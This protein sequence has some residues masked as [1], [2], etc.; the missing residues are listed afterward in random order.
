MFLCDKCDAQFEQTPKG[1][2]EWLVHRAEHSQGNTAK[3]ATEEKIKPMSAAQ[4]REEKEKELAERKPEPIKLQYQWTGECPDCFTR[5]DSL[6]L[7][8]GQK[9]G[10]VVSVAF[11]TKCKKQIRERVVKKL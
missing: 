8:A 6:T 2:Q 1:K 3:T 9:E 10:N 5:L 11:C 7:E 4:I